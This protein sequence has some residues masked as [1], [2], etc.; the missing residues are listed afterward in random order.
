MTTKLQPGTK[1]PVS[2]QH[3][4]WFRRIESYYVGAGRRVMF[5][6][7]SMSMRHER[8]VTIE[9]IKQKHMHQKAA[10][11]FAPSSAGYRCS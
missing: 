9:Q 4:S 3:Q 8:I 1:L 11:A 5:A 10:I 6:W 2:V 7:F